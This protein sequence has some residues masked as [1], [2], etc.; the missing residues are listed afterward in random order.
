MAQVVPS[1]VVTTAREP[2]SL[3]ARPASAVSWKFTNALAKLGEPEPDVV[4]NV[5][6]VVTDSAYNTPS[7]V[8]G[9][10][11][12]SGLLLAG[13]VEFTMKALSNR[14]GFDTTCSTIWTPPL[15]VAP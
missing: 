9:V 3:V 6:P 8:E 15:V 10:A 4:A 13:M 11:H 7:S 14:L 5:P 1:F 12:D 2:V